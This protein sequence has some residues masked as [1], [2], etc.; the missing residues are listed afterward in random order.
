[1]TMDNS[2]KV[3]NRFEEDIC[4][5]S[6]MSEG[7]VY[8]PHDMQGDVDALVRFTDDQWCILAEHHLVLRRLAE[9]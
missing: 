8:C 4:P 5:M 2:T 3:L 7:V 9:G 1:M 6:V